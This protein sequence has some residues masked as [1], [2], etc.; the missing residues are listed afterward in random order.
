MVSITIKM[1]IKEHCNSGIHQFLLVK[2]F[3]CQNSAP[4]DIYPIGIKLSQVANN[5]CYT[6]KERK[7]NFDIC[8]YLEVTIFL[9]SQ[10]DSMENQKCAI[11]VKQ[12]ITKT[13]MDS[14]KIQLHRVEHM[15]SSYIAIILSSSLLEFLTLLLAS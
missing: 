8:F 1:K 3:H 13:T 7:L 15:L 2:I 14:G 5:N 10:K 11:Q 6:T 9:K 4:Y 12:L